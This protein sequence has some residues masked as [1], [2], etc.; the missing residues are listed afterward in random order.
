MEFITK[1]VVGLF[2]LAGIYM[3]WLWYLT[4]ERTKAVKPAILRALREN[5]GDGMSKLELIE[6]LVSWSFREY[7][8]NMGLDELETEGLICWRLKDPQKPESEQNLEMIITIDG[9]RHI[10]QMAV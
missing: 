2:L 5:H 3:S 8:I 4:A 9:A 7:I 1:I 6:R 10:H